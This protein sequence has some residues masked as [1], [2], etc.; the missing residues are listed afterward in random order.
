MDTPPLK[1]LSPLARRGDQLR[2]V[3]L[4]CY[5]YWAH[6]GLRNEPLHPIDLLC[7]LLD[8]T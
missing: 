8:V 2:Y 1:V 6:C 4:S 7:C 5:E 3:E